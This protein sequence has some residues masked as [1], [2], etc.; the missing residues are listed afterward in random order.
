MKGIG[1][2]QNKSQPSRVRKNSFSG[3]IKGK[4]STSA[5]FTRQA[6]RMNTGTKRMQGSK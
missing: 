1:N 2:R 3:Q 4:G 5:S 6:K